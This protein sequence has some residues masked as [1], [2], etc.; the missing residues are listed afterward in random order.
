MK[1]QVKINYEKYRDADLGYLA[2]TVHQALSENAEFFTEPNPPLTEL[3]AA[4]ADYDEKMQFT[5]GKGSPYNSE[6]KNASKRALVDVLRRLAFY[7]N[8][9]CNGVV[10]QLLS[11]GFRLKDLRKDLTV[12]TT[13]TR[14]RLVDG[15]LSGQLAL[16]FDS[17]PKASE[18][19][20]Q[21]GTIISGE[22]VWGDIAS[23]RNGRVR[24][25]NIIRNLTPAVT[26]YARVRARNPE[27]LSDWSE[28]VSQIAR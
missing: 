17:V 9:T 21:L 13:P 16:L 12:P 23:F 3:E 14:V 11:S 28:P 19:E 25:N 15:E 2:S 24:R 20:Y 4:I 5:N 1:R 22:I 7:V 27:G 10:H 6:S 18:Y 8:T 26:Y